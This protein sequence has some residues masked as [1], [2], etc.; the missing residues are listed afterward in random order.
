MALKVRTDLAYS[1]L[2]FVSFICE[3]HN[4]NLSLMYAMKCSPKSLPFLLQFTF[5]GH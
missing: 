1:L 4:I 5:L 3:V 2:I